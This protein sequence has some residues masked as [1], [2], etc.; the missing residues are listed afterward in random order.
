MGMGYSLGVILTDGLA[1]EVNTV[2]KGQ[3]GNAYPVTMG[4]GDECDAL[5]SR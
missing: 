4:C 1:N 2:P 5:E 3:S